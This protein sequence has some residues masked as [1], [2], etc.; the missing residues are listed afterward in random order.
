MG[1]TKKQIPKNCDAFFNSVAYKSG[2][3]GKKLRERATETGL[4]KPEWYRDRLNERSR[5]NYRNLIKDMAGFNYWVRE[6]EDVVPWIIS[7]AI[8]R[9]IT[10]IQNEQKPLEINPNSEWPSSIVIV[11]DGDHYDATTKDGKSY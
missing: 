4:S 5:E 9:P 3:T 6:L 1:L 2:Y 8:R 10:I 11:R 7:D